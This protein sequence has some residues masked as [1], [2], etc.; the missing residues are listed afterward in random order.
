MK[1]NSSLFIPTAKRS[2][3]LGKLIYNISKQNIVPDGVRKSPF[4]QSFISER[5]LAITLVDCNENLNMSRYF[6]FFLF[7]IFKHFIDFT[8]NI[9]SLRYDM[10]YIMMG[11][12][13]G[14][15]MNFFPLK[16]SKISLK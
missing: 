4:K 3:I 11:R 15:F 6:I 13:L 2:K 14:A 5:N 9:F 1:A 16:K 8:L 10:I 7:R 12:F